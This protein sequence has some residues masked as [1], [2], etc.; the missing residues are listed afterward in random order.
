[1]HGEQ[2]KKW[3]YIE[4]ILR[5]LEISTDNSKFQITSDLVEYLDESLKVPKIGGIVILGLY[6]KTDLHSI[7]SRGVKLLNKSQKYQITVDLVGH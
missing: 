6:Q 2:T 3:I 5:G 7:F 1:M 4:Y